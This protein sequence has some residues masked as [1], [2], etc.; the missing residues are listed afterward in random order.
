MDLSPAENKLRE[1]APKRFDNLS[2][3]KFTYDPKSDFEERFGI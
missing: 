3:G 2:V 1:L